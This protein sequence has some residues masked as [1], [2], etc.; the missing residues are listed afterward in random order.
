M[1][2]P[3]VERGTFLAI[4]S[5]SREP[6]HRLLRIWNVY[7]EEPRHNEPLYN[8]VLSIKNDFFLIV[9]V[10][11]FIKLLLIAVYRT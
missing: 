8:E 4:F 3:L 1:N 10:L 2:R 9:E 5:P 7:T 11:D 6:V